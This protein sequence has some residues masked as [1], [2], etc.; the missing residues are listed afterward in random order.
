MNNLPLV[1]VLGLVS[2]IQVHLAKALE[3]QGIEVFDQIKVGLQKGGQPVP[4]GRKV[5]VIYTIGFTLNHTVFVWAVLAQPYGP[6]ALF[7]SLF[8]VGLVF[9]IFYAAL[10]MKETISRREG[11]GAAS[12]I[13]GTLIIG[14]E[15]VNRQDLDRFTMDLEALLL[16]LVLFLIAGLVFILFANRTRSLSLVGLAFGVLAG[17]LGSLDPFLKGVGQGLGGDPSII[18]KSGLGMVVFLASFVIGFISFLVTQFGFARKVRASILV[19]AYNASYVAFPVLLQTILLPAFS[20]YW[21]T[22]VG[23]GLI[24]A[25]V[26]LMQSLWSGDRLV[27]K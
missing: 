2:T 10:V 25:G 4:G 6:P 9:L 22:V 1:I 24:V 17:G 20:I 12:I 11:W 19:P 7:T 27:A 13:A 21:T 18:P 5:P 15:N 8:G 16:V 3:R 23:L 14:V 26:F